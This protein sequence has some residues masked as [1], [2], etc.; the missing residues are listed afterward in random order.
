MTKHFWTFKH[1]GN[2]VKP[3]SQILPM[4]EDDNNMNMAVMSKDK[5]YILAMNPYEDEY[6]LPV[7]FPEA[8]CAT[9]GYRTSETEDFASID[10]A[11]ADGD[12]WT[13]KLVPMSQTTYV[14]S[15]GAC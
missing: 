3:G 8:V 11:I 6:D 13:I 5:Y 12:N 2:F 15:K 14:F 10:S 4:T 9:E 7:I 1:F